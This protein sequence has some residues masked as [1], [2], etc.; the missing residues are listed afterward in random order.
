MNL[1][2]F[3]SPMYYERILGRKSFHEVFLPSTLRQDL[4]WILSPVL[5]TKASEKFDSE[6]K[7]I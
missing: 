5:F 1:S 7:N 4:M 2:L 3:H 6:K